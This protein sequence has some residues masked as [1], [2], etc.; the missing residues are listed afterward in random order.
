MLGATALAILLALDFLLGSTANRFG[1]FDGVILLVFFIAFLFFATR[2][3]LRDRRKDRFLQETEQDQER[4][5][6]MHWAVACLLTVAGLAGVLLGSD[7]TVDGAS[8]V[9]AAMGMSQAVIGL[10]IV[11]AGTG[12]PE[13]A[14][15]I[16]AAFRKEPD[17]AVGNVVGSCIFNLLAV[18]GTTAAISPLPM[19]SI[20]LLR[21]FPVMLAL[22]AL[23]L[24]LA[25]SGHIINR[26]EGLLLL[27][28]Y[29]AYVTYLVLQ[30]G[31]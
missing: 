1:T 30:T 25:L 10:T 23:V 29:V 11:G 21:D 22:T 20:V 14:T 15:S 26:W 6:E 18:L 3:A 9:A 7:W 8:G 27:S 16:V 24:P 19:E 12:L 5:K 2:T 28:G 17:I 13:L 31:G 4:E